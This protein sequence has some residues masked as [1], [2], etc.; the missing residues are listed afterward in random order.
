MMLP[1]DDRELY[2]LALDLQERSITTQPLEPLEDIDATILTELK[3]TTDEFK[4]RGLPEMYHR[5]GVYEVRWAEPHGD[6]A[7]VHTDRFRTFDEAFARAKELQAAFEK[8]LISKEEASKKLEAYRR[9]LS[10][11]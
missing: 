2:E 3:T 10:R 1:G 9:K 11:R 8:G 4:R 6:S 7:T 5:G